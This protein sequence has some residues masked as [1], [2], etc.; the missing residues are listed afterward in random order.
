MTL[1]LPEPR[2]LS[3]LTITA[4]PGARLPAA[5]EVEVSDGKGFE[6]VLS[7]KPSRARLDLVW[8]NGHPE[9]AADGRA[10]SATLGGETVAAVRIRSRDGSRLTVG[11]VVVH[12]APPQHPR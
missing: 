1:E 7:L 4:A 6:G 9:F 3:G 10:I 12:P 11:A 8:V 5:L 2:P